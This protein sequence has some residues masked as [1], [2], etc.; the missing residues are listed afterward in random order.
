[1][2]GVSGQADSQWVSPEGEREIGFPPAYPGLFWWHQ[3]TSSD[4]LDL[5]VGLSPWG[6][7]GW[8]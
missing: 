8:W 1:M 2:V 6:P 7:G 4:G 5:R 3:G